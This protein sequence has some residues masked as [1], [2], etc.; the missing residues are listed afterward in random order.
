MLTQFNTLHDQINTMVDYNKQYGE[1]LSKKSAASYASARAIVLLLLLIS[2]GMGI[3]IGTLITR[4]MTRTL[5][6]I[7]QRINS[8]NTICVENL[9]TAVVALEQG[10]L[11]VPIATGTEPM[12]NQI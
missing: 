12:T 6:E 10:D 9:N 1:S 2:I 11:T 4:Y 8:L 5:A 7:S 3:L